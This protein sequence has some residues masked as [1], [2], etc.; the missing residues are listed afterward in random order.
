MCILIATNIYS[1]YTKYLYINAAAAMAPALQLYPWLLPT[2]LSQ[3]Y[4]TLLS[5]IHGQRTLTHY[6]I[7]IY[8]TSKH[9]P[10]QPSMSSHHLTSY[11][12]IRDGWFL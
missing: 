12:I 8:I 2:L 6:Y 7:P 4:V 5:H 1:L 9:L 11:S 3:Q 10:F